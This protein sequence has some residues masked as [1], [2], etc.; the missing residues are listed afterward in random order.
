[1]SKPVFI[2]SMFR[3][4]STY[5]FNVFRKSESG[6][7]C[8]EEPTHE[9][10]FLAQDNPELLL[11][12][13]LKKMNDLL[14]HPQINIQYF[15]ELYDVWPAWKDKITEPSV[16]DNYFGLLDPEI[17]IDY[18]ISLITAAKGR[19][20]MQECRTAL[21]I[22][23]IRNRIGGYHI[24]LWRNP[25]DQWMSYKVAEY[26]DTVNQIIINGPCIP[27]E[28][29]ILKK[30][31]KMIP[32]IGQG[33]EKGFSYFAER[34]L[35]S[36]ESYL[37]FYMLWCLT[38]RHGSLFSDLLLNI[39]QLTDSAE[40]QL[41]TK[42]LLLENDIAGIDFS[43]CRIFQGY[44]SDMDKEFFMVLEKE[45]HECLFLSGWSDEDVMKL[46]DLRKQYEPAIRSVS[47]D[48]D[49]ERILAQ[50]IERL[51]S[52][53]RFYESKSAHKSRE[54]MDLQVK[55]EESDMKV[56]ATEAILREVYNSPSW[57]ITAPLRFVFGS[58]KKIFN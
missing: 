21:R 41:Y 9:L 40:Y 22:N 48:S 53:E 35:D 23:D 8:Y 7:W 10:A 1:M 4:G 33:L 38:L 51:L 16:Y 57:R 12:F 24:F 37:V 13:D 18:W 30:R 29:T 36:S 34:P 32:C 49:R 11:Q 28:V 19:P 25:W 31:L 44:Y 14:R 46:S 52:L 55:V 5:L 54:I 50:Q 27:D 17:G 26:F 56:L 6:Y 3:A 47:L 45:V 15:Q 2:H 58:L 42:R 39:D 20:V 43:E